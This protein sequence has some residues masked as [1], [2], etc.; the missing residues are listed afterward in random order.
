M[1]SVGNLT[2][3]VRGHMLEAFDVAPRIRALIAHFDD[4]N[5]AH[6]AVL[7]AK[8]QVE[9]LTPLLA[10]CARH[11]GLADGMDELRACREALRSFFAGRKAALLEERLAR[12]DEELARQLGH[13]ARL[14]E[15]K[16]AQQGEERELRRAI[17]DNGGDRIERLAL[18]IER[19]EG[20]RQRRFEKARRYD[21][22]RKKLGLQVLAS[23][24]DFLSH[25]QALAPLREAA[26]DRQAALQNELNESSANFTEGRR[27]HA[28]LRAEITSLKARRTTS[29]RSRSPCAP[30]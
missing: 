9:L 23:V 7:K 25:R 15:K 2:E 21:Q 24:D 27:E 5:R 13:I 20:D 29:F 10:D 1:K 17:G 14:A 22:L 12:L 6:E 3:F 16:V 18:E 4:L 30:R 11:D 8:R 28:A 19:K 26:A